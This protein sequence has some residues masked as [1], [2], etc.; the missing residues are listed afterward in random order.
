MEDNN[1]SY[2]SLPSPSGRLTQSQAVAAVPLI[3]AN[4]PDTYVEKLQWNLAKGPHLEFLNSQ[5]P[6]YSA[7]LSEGSA[8]ASEQLNSV[9]NGCFQ[10]FSWRLK[11]T[12]DPNMP[13]NALIN[14][15]I[16]PGCEIE[17][18]KK[19]HKVIAMQKSIYTWLD[20]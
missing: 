11:V 8:K 16:D 20:Y 3:N 4:D 7:S 18:E 5:L 2:S 6:L 14:P 19:W 12:E 17:I 10:H 13:Y 15:P 1:N 9:I